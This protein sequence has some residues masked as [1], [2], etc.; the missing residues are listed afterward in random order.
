MFEVFEVPQGGRCVAVPPGIRACGLA[1]TTRTTTRG[2][3]SGNHE[4]G[5]CAEWEERRGPFQVQLQA[6]DHRAPHFPG[7]SSGP[8]LWALHYVL[9]GLWALFQGQVPGFSPLEEASSCAL[10]MFIPHLRAGLHRVEGPVKWNECVQAGP[11]PQNTVP[12]LEAIKGNACIALTST[13]AV[14][15]EAAWSLGGTPGWD[16][17]PHIKSHTVTLS[18]SPCLT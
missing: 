9:P 4:R 5:V 6:Q 3:L 12:P 16:Q 8:L 17:G 10:P 1:V 7:N 18:D 14:E 2:L 13:A 15:G 11:C